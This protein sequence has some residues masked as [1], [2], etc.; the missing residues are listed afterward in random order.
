MTDGLRKQFKGGCVDGP[1]AVKVRGPAVF[2]QVTCFR[3]FRLT[4][5]W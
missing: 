4:F 3:G 5:A 2:R 1:P